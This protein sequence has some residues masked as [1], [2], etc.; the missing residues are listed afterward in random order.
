MINRTTV[1]KATV[2]GISAT[3]A[4]VLLTGAALAWHPNGK[5]TKGVTNVTAGGTAVSSADT[6]GTAVTAKPGDTLKYTIVISNNGAAHNQGWND[7]GSTKLVDT[8]PAGVELVGGSITE[9]IGVVAAQK[10]VTRVITVK[11]KADAKDGQI[12]DNKACFTGEATN[13]EAGKHQEGCDHAIVKVKVTPTPTPTPSPSVSPSPTPQVL[14]D[15]TTLPETGMA[16]ALGAAAGLTAM[17]GA[18]VAY[19]RSRKNLR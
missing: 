2:T 4:L 15:T 1:S 3:A 12:I 19:L 14:G 7:M 5:I 9:N 13:N 8:L 11:V 10:S 6:T 16:G 17:T 18:T